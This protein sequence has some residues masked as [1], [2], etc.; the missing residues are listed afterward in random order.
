ML[1]TFG[2]SSG[3]TRKSIKFSNIDSITNSGNIYQII[4]D[5]ANRFE[6]H[7]IEGE[8]YH[9]FKTAY[10]NWKKLTRTSSSSHN[11]CL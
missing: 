1:D 5:S 11:Q 9:R 3:K 4:M 10:E 7:T 2:Y 8:D 6:L